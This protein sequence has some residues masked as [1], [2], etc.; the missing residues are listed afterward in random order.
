M[1]LQYYSAIIEDIIEDIFGLFSLPD[2]ARG[3]QYAYLANS[4]VSPGLS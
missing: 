1:Q 4:D 2:L 3:G